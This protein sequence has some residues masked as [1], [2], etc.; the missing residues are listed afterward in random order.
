VRAY[1][2]NSV[3]TAYGEEVS[4]A[5][6]PSTYVISGSVKDESG[7]ALQ[8]V[9]LTLTNGG[10][11]TVTDANGHYE[12]AVDAGWSGTAAPEK[13]GFTFDPAER[14]YS[15]VSSD[16]TGQDYTAVPVKVYELQH[17]IAVFKI[18]TGIDAS[19]LIDAADDKDGD[20]KIGLPEAVYI[21]EVVAGL[22]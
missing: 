16:Q 13:E 4:F 1:A 7:I 14:T 9:N 8:D 20:G 11:S 6:A 15:T 10:G 5:T 12:Q 19:E 21:L 3:G 18:L 22:K 2:V 17:A